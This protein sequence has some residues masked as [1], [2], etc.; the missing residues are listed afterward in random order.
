MYPIVCWFSHD[1]F[2]KQKH[3]MGKDQFSQD[4]NPKG[5]K[6]LNIEHTLFTLTAFWCFWNFVFSTKNTIVLRPVF[7]SVARISTRQA[8]PSPP[9]GSWLHQ[10]PS[11]LQWARE[12]RLRGSQ[13]FFPP[14]PPGFRLASGNESLRRGCRADIAETTK[15]RQR[16]RLYCTLHIYIWSY[17]GYKPRRGSP[18]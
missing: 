2:K 10:R 3:E 4:V 1:F 18:P 14:N 12:R 5:V 13:W 16:F 7:L 6:L 11:P 8:V 17:Y 9:H 15:M